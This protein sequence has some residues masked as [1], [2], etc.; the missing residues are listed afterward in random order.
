[1]GEIAR[2]L[3]Q[4][5]RSIV[6]GCFSTSEQQDT[7]GYNY[8]AEVESMRLNTFAAVWH[9][10]GYASSPPQGSHGLVFNLNAQPENQFCFLYDPNTRF[11]GLKPGEV[12]VGNQLKQTFVKF[13][14]NGNVEITST[15]ELTVNCENATINCMSGVGNLTVDAATTTLT[16]DLVVQGDITGTNVTA[17]ADVADSGGTLQANRNTY[18]IHTHPESGGG[19]TSAPNQP[20]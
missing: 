7:T 13:L 8:V 16:G 14:E 1:M 5:M 19:T 9:D 12:I 3:L 11:E 20:Q 4:R 6:R 10:Y 15:A 18:N 2:S 17:T